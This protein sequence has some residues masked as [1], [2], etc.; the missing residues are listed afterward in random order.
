MVALMI[1]LVEM[2]GLGVVVGKAWSQEELVLVESRRDPRQR[3]QSR[4]ST[5]TT[6]CNWH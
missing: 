2:R 5:I 4:G 3:S 6:I 1:V